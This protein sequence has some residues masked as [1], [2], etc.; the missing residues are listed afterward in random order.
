MKIGVLRI[1]GPPTTLPQFA[2]YP[3]MM[4]ELIGRDAHDWRVF[5]TDELELPP[6]P[7]SCDAYV[8]TG[9]AAGLYE[10]H[11]W[12]PP[13]LEFIRAAKGRAKLVGI[14]FGHQAIAQALG[15]RVVNSP[16]GW[17][18]GQNEYRVVRQEPWMDGAE[19]LRLPASHQD[20]LVE[21][22]PGA[23]VYACSDF[24]PL[25]AL[26]YRDHPTISIQLHPEFQPVYAKALIEA[27]RGHVFTDE[28]ADRAIA[29]YTGPDDRERMGRWINA[30]LTQD[31]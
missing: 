16:K 12:I 10:N 13:L 26:V 17:A 14:C 20:Q 28:Q 15:G 19:T 27:R 4:M 18:V 8:I 22:P 9:S 25:G 2:S 31:A 24:T 6:T 29:S 7:E 1:G 11:A 23:E 3:D 5:A 30:F 21:L